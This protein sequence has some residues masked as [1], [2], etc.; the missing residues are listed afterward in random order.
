MR[1]TT[2]EIHFVVHVKSLLGKC[3]IL[4]FQKAELLVCTS[5]F[6]VT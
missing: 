4:G 6:A 5:G 3:P 2:K 1:S